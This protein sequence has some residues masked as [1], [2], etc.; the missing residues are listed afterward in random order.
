M[1]MCW[2]QTHTHT[3]SYLQSHKLGFLDN[4][5]AFHY[6]EATHIL[7]QAGHLSNIIW[8]CWRALALSGSR[9]G[10]ATWFGVDPSPGLCFYSQQCWPLFVQMSSARSTRLITSDI[11]WLKLCYHSCLHSRLFQRN[12]KN[13][14]YYLFMW[15]SFK[16]GHT[17]FF[18]RRIKQFCAVLLFR[19]GLGTKKHLSLEN[20]P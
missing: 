6:K 2:S 15:S 5:A 18:L 7:V 14:Y 10:W 16:W 11:S 1:T 9:S 8:L 13:V 3:H 12:K 20:M 19:L 4:V 17:T